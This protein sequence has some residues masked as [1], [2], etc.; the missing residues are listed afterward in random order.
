M[1]LPGI[2]LQAGSLGGASGSG[3]TEVVAQCGSYSGGNLSYAED[4]AS[5][6]YGD[7]R[8]S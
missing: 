2:R 8:F 5:P 3:F 1:Q 4:H 7:G 6:P